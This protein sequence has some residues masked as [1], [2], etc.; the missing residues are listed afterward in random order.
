[1]SLTGLENGL[2][3]QATDLHLGVREVMRSNGR[4]VGELARLCGQPVVKLTQD[5]KR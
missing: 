4:A 2:E 1:M 5:L 3:G